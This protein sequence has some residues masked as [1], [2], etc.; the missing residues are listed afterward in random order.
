MNPLDTLV[1]LDLP[2]F[3]FAH[4]FKHNSLDNGQFC[5]CYKGSF[6]WRNSNPDNRGKDSPWSLSTMHQGS[7]LFEPS[8]Q[9]LIASEIFFV[10]QIKTRTSLKNLLTPVA[11]VLV[12]FHQTG[13]SV[14]ICNAIGLIMS[15]HSPAS[16][17]LKWFMGFIQTNLPQCLVPLL[18]H[19]CDACLSLTEL[20]LLL[21]RVGGAAI[22]SNLP[23]KVI[24]PRGF[25]RPRWDIIAATDA[26]Q[27]ER[28]L[29]HVNRQRFQL[30]L[31]GE[32]A[33]C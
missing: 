10:G 33:K 26:E 1:C 8:F 24:K 27:V 7:W 6:P 9:L 23:V 18:V 5:K 21:L 17:Y 4:R 13:P 12:V 19:E 31:R 28:T 20:M 11:R 30:G 32:N 25:L 14:R 22:I 2:T 15:A 16:H 3:V 29:S